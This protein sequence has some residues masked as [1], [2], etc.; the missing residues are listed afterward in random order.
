M[1]MFHEL[2]EAPSTI[3][4]VTVTTLEINDNFFQYNTITFEEK[5]KEEAEHYAASYCKENLV[6]YYEIKQAHINMSRD[7]LQQAAYDRLTEKQKKVQ[8]KAQQE[9]DKL[10]ERK[11]SLLAITHQPKES[12]NDWQF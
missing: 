4:L 1:I 2:R 9:L 12:E 3:F 5:T 6:L 8:A 10:E 11:Q 7:Q